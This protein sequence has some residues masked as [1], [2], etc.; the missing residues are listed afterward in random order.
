MTIDFLIELIQPSIRS[1]SNFF[2]LNYKWFVRIN[3]DLPVRKC[4][5]SGRRR[6]NE[7]RDTHLLLQHE[8]YSCSRVCICLSITTASKMFL[9]YNFSVN[10]FRFFFVV[11]SFRDKFFFLVFKWLL[12]LLFRRRSRRLNSFLFLSLFHNQ[13]FWIDVLFVF[14]S[15]FLLLNNVKRK[16]TKLICMFEYIS[17]SCLSVCSVFVLLLWST[18]KNDS[19]SLCSDLNFS[20]SIQHNPIYS[21]HFWHFSFRFSTC[22]KHTHLSHQRQFVGFSLLIKFQLSEIRRFH[23][24]N[25]DAFGFPSS[26]PLSLSRFLSFFLF[27]SIVIGISFFQQ[28]KFLNSFRNSISNCFINRFH[29]VCIAQFE[30][31]SQHC[32]LCTFRL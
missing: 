8:N 5:G 31:I 7:M 14:F 1:I 27:K 19:F 6:T 16:S 11:F 29:L 21:Q 12:L 20:L 24:S 3:H 15:S 26:L 13:V 4:I 22:P 23:S 32:F 28:H 18:R 30:I 25:F 2:L 17:K 9:F 10:W